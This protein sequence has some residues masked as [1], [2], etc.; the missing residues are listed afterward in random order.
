MWLV[1]KVLIIMLYFRW[2]CW[3]CLTLAWLYCQGDI[4]Y[5]H[6]KYPTYPWTHTIFNKTIISW[7][8][9]VFALAYG[10]I[11]YFRIQLYQKI[12]ENIGVVYSKTEMYCWFFHWM[13]CWFFHWK[14]GFCQSDCTSSVWLRISVS[15]KQWNLDCYFVT[16][17]TSKL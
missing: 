2:G 13:Y 15:G 9:L 3:P 12:S 14:W 6:W 8:R 11:G 16:L 5:I 7:Y 4:T 10:G 1:I 17:N